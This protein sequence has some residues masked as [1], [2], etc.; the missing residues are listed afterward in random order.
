MENEGQQKKKIFSRYEVFVIAVL[1]FLQFTIILDF[2]VL[3]PL[4]AQLML[5]LKIT[6]AQF[7]WVV[8]AYAFSAG[9]SWPS[10]SWLC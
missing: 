6:T 1:S 10:H 7:G 2:M 3:S 8:S 4:G 5:E 9:S